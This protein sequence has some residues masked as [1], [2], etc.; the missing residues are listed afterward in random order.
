M[1]NNN[2]NILNSE[3]NNNDKEKNNSINN[4]SN[5]NINNINNSQINSLNNTSENL[6]NSKKVEKIKKQNQFDTLKINTELNKLGDDKIYIDKKNNMFMYNNKNEKHE[7]YYASITLNEGLSELKYIGG[8]GIFYTNLMRN[9][10]GYLEYEKDQYLGNWKE[11]TKSGFGIYVYDGAEKN[12]NVNNENNI[13]EIQIEEEI[14][15]GNWENDIKQGKGIYICKKNKEED[16]TQGDYDFLLGYFEDDK[17][18]F[19]YIISKKDDCKI[20]YKGKIND[21]GEKEDEES[22]YFENFNDNK[23]EDINKSNEDNVDD[24]NEK[25]GFYGE[26]KN[27]IM[28]KGRIIVFEKDDEINKSYYFEKNENNLELIEEEKKEE[29]IKKDENNNLEDDIDNKEEYNFDIDKEIDKDEKILEENKYIKENNI[30]KDEIIS[31]TYKFYSEIIKDIDL[32]RIKEKKEYFDN[33]IQKIMELI[34]FE[35]KKE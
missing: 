32:Q 17:F 29:E 28:N 33:N 25:K 20:I 3:E 22:I 23:E 7:K 15:I 13:N 30:N 18:Q 11:D 2:S 12:I 21:K 19:G 27:N 35:I 31:N 1:N 26:F 24:T 34:N 6:K 8:L 10:F 16:I 14:Y 5:I 4:E 9:G